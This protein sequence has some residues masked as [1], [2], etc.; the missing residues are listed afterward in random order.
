MRSSQIAKSV[1]AVKGGKI[2][3]NNSEHWP[4]YQLA[5]ATVNGMDIA[6]TPQLCARIAVMVRGFSHKC[7]CAQLA[8]TQRYV[9]MRKPAGDYWD[10]VDEKLKSIRVAAEKDPEKLVKYEFLQILLIHL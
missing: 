7:F 3:S 4:I 8:S 6:I 1:G 9:Y 10:A 2:S 5:Q